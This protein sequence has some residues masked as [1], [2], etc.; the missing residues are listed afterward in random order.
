MI[1]TGRVVGIVKRDLRDFCGELSEERDGLGIITLMDGRCSEILVRPR[2]LD[3]IREKKIL[4]SIDDWPQD[5]LLP[6]GHITKVFGNKEDVDVENEVILFEFNVETRQ[7]SQ[8]VLNCLPPEQENWRIPQ[9]EYEKRVDLRSENICS[10][11][12]PGCKDIDDA[13]HA[14]VL[15]NGNFEVGVHIADVT[16][17]VKPDT[18]IDKEASE[19]CTTVYLVN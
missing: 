19:R 6:I 3:L 8:K 4:V 5:S 1:L 17:F 18:P 14:K 2:N 11:D 15:E 12:P 9:E 10:V 7:F 13:L 16:Y